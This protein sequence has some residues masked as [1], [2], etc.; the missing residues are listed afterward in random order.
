MI[1]AIS[2]ISQ[3]G[4]GPGPL[5]ILLTN[6]TAS[7]PYLI[8]SLASSTEAIQHIFI[9]VRMLYVMIKIYTILNKDIYCYLQNFQKGQNKKFFRPEISKQLLH[10]PV[11]LYI[12]TQNKILYGK[13]FKPPFDVE[14]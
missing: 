2:A 14:I 3:S 13:F 8:A 10:Q 1:F 4:I 9:L 6:P 7:A 12:I 11:L 5:G